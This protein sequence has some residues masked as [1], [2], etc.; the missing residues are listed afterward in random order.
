[1]EQMENNPRFTIFIPVKNGR[2][3]IAPCVESI[4]AQTYK[5]FDLVILAGYSTDGTCA[6]LRTLEARDARIKVIFS[7]RE[8][9]IEDNW[10]R[11]RTVPKNEFMTI[12]GYDDLLEPDFLE[13]INTLIQ[14]EPE[15]NLYLT[16]FKLIDSEGKLIRHCKPIPKYETAA[17]FLA[18]RMAEIRDSFGTGYVM[19]S[20]H[21]DKLGGIPPYP[22]LL[23]A[24]DTLW[25]G[26]MGNSFK[27]TSHRVCCSYRLHAGSVSG[28]PDFAALF[29]GLKQY[30]NYLRELAKVNDDLANIIKHY[31]PQYVASRCQDYY[32]SLL[33]TSPW[34]KSVDPLTLSEIEK[35]MDEFT[36]DITLDKKCSNRGRRIMMKYWLSCIA[37]WNGRIMDICMKDDKPF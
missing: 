6:W 5:N 37:R 8:L 30:L 21:Y 11:I 34:G 4:L 15:A 7:D 33:K 22:D 28:K 13:E 25:L 2:N 12:V 1:M 24:D 18:A 3:Y 26:L 32:C 23:Y 9:G 27:A 31:G 20:D 29:N 35:I 16:H 36:G 10:G 17:E 19:R 14:S